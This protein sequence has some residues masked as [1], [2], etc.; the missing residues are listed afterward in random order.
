MYGTITSFGLAF[1]LCSTIQSSTLV[2]VLQPQHCLNNVGLGCSPFARHYLGNHYCFLLLRVL[3]CFS[4]PR[5][6]P[7]CSGYPDF[8]GMGCPIR[9]S[10]DQRLFAPPRSFSQLVTSFIASE[11]HRHPPCALINFFSILIKCL[12]ILYL[13]PNMSKNS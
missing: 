4:S 10:P 3:R 12:S 11:S 9:T 2:A 8:I 6:P 7:D 5:S 1:Q 13:L